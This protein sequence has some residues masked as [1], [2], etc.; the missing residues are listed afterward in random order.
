MTSDPAESRI[1]GGSAAIRAA[2]T[3]V[4]GRYTRIVVPRPGA[5]SIEMPPPLCCT[6]P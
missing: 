6:I 1:G 3:L 4:A 2:A 5:E